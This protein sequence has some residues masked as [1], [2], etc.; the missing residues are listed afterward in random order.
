MFFLQKFLFNKD[1]L[2]EFKGMEFLTQTE[3][4]YILYLWNLMV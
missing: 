1:I 2:F 4:V 3:I